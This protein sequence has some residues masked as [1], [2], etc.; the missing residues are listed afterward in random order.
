[1]R[2]SYAF[3]AIVFTLLTS[4]EVIFLQWGMYSE[5]TYDKGD[6]VDQTT[7][8]LNS[9]AGQVTKFVSQ[10]WLEQ[11]YQFLLSLF[12]LAIIYLVFIFVTNRFWIATLLFGILFTIYGTADNIKMGLRNEP[13]IPADLSFVTGGDSG[14]LLSFIPEESQSFVN[15]V[16][17]VLA[18]FI[19]CCIVF[20]IIDGRRSFIYCSWKRPFASIEK[21]YWHSYPHCCRNSQYCLA[22]F[23]L[24][25]SQYS[26]FLGI[27]FRRIAWVYSFLIRY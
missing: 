27:L 20:F 9:V 12:A 1:M 7:K 2:F 22:L 15:S 25:E 6:E 19:C 21:L 17:T 5:P 18:W 16:I 10:M 8:I 23:V 14:K 3:Y 4:A 11:K 26:W 24:L 13:I